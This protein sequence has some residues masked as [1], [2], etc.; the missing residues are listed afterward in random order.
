MLL[1]LMYCKILFFA[2]F[3]CLFPCGKTFGNETLCVNSCV[4][5]NLNNMNSEES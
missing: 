4:S 2:F 1:C 5:I 3:Q